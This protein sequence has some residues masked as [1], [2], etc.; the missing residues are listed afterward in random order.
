MESK[1]KVFYLSIFFLFYISIFGQ[2]LEPKISSD[3]DGSG[4]GIHTSW[5]DLG[6]VRDDITEKMF[7]AGVKW[8]RLGVP[9]GY[10]EHESAGDYYFTSIDTIINQLTA[11][12][13][14]PY[15]ILSDAN[16]LYNPN[17]H[18]PVP[19]SNVYFEAWLAYVDTVV[20]RY[21][22]RVNHWEIWNEPNLD[23]SWLP[24]ADPLNY[25]ALA[26]ST[27]SV[28]R[29][30]DADAVICLGGMALVDIKFIKA[31]LAN[32]VSQY[33][34]KIGVHPYRT[35]PEAPQ[36]LLV[37][38]PNSQFE[39]PYSSY[40]DEIRALKDT[41]ALFDDSLEIWD[42]EVGFL[43]DSIYPNPLSPDPFNPQHTSQTTQAKY[44][45]RRYILNLKENIEITTWTV[46]WDLGSLSHNMGKSDWVD[47][48]S[49][50]SDVDFSEAP[51][52]GI[53]YMCMNHTFKIW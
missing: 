43:S 44:L 47:N 50:L 19:D 12:S 14:T 17:R 40:E 16:E 3:I 29:A 24:E 35:L 25:S 30:N 10:V 52:F 37:W 7:E 1:R 27:S 21:R 22:D 49:E 34:D 31:C 32:G 36:N 6:P 26:C 45:A 15:L 33:V 48:Y 39:S 11:H 8:C 20:K 4:I 9:W 51:F 28:I 5:L 41:I 13:I 42:T 2:R 38:I 18:A 23:E 53:I 46:D